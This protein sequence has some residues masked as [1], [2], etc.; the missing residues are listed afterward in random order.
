MIAR[1]SHAIQR[2]R[3][4]SIPDREFVKTF[5]V[6]GGYQL[7]KRRVRPFVNR[8]RSSRPRTDHA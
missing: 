8:V 6:N 5:S 1:E 2:D 3:L 7:L 4:R